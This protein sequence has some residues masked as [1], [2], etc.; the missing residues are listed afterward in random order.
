[1][2]LS[3]RP[4]QFG[5]RC[6]SL[7]N[8]RLRNPRRLMCFPHGQVAR[9]APVTIDRS[10]PLCKSC[11]NGHYEKTSVMTRPWKTSARITS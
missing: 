8:T 4:P 6:M 3:S 9:Q 11:H 1:M 7:S 5:Q 2:I 10:W